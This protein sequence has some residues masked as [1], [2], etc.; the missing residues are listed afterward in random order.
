L[1]FRLTVRPYAP[2]DAAAVAAIYSQGIA[3]RMA[4]FETEPRTP[5]DIG[6]Q[7]ATRV[8]RYPAVV[9]EADGSVVATAWTSEYR[10]RAAYAAIAE[11]SVYVARDARG[12]GAGR[13]ALSSLIN[14]AEARGFLK[15]VSRVFPENV[16]SL[17]LCAA[18]GFRQVG[19]YRRH[20]RLD[21][22]WRD[23]VIVERL[24]GAARD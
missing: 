19:T 18:L 3:E 16:A 6:E 20:G 5:D 10:S 23:C 15:L 24:L 14:A 11:F 17:R 7:F 1:A 21:G 2:A 8:T 22:E 12:R 13:L 9:V 4:T